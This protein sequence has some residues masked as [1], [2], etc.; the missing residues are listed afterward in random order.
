MIR[1]SLKVDATGKSS[2]VGPLLEAPSDRVRLVGLSYRELD[3]EDERPEK[4]RR[5]G[6]VRNLARTPRRAGV[7][8]VGRAP[9]DG[10]EA[11]SAGPR[12]ASAG[13]RPAMSLL[14]PA[15]R[16]AIAVVRV[17]GPGS[18]QVADA[19]FRP[20]RG[21]GLCRTATGRIR[22]GRIGLGGGHEVVAVVV[23]DEPPAVEL[24]CHGGVAA[25]ELVIDALE[26]AGAM[27]CGPEFTVHTSTDDLIAAEAKIDLCLAP[28]LK[29]A[30]IFLEQ[31]EGALRGE[32]LN[33]ARL[34]DQD[35]ESTLVCL[36]ELLGRS[37]RRTCGCFRAGRS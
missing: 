33:L 30:E 7:A 1:R 11:L 32:L 2:I 24:Q 12:G 35:P 37:C 8:T 5:S 4:A 16:G 20:H 13:G 34:I 26:K 31:A 18:I 23:D 6:P 10:D 14:T 19:V 22:L 28:T 15:G 36:D 27:R 9:C 17:F 21:G 3:V 25:V 29:T